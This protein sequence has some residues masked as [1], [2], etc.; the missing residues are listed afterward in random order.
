MEN[1]V[2][3]KQQERKCVDVATFFSLP[4][5]KAQAL[6]QS[7]SAAAVDHLEPSPTSI[8]QQVQRSQPRLASNGRA[9]RRVNARQL[10]HAAHTLLALPRDVWQQHIWPHL[11]SPDK[12]AMRATCKVRCGQI[13]HCV[14][15]GSARQ[16]GYGACV[17][18]RKRHSTCCW[19]CR[20]QSP[21]TD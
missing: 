6:L 4:W 3:C 12:A 8:M 2:G 1:V 5:D 7:G 18:V 14:A 17:H 15:G 9:P 21:L 16:V 11:D 19:T 13:M 20:P 10:P